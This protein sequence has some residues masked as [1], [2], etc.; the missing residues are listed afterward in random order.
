[1]FH[2]KV[3]ILVLNVDL[4]MMRNFFSC[5]CTDGFYMNSSLIS[6]LTVKTQIKQQSHSDTKCSFDITSPSILH[7]VRWRYVIQIHE[8]L[9]LE[10]VWDGSVW[11][12]CKWRENTKNKLYYN[13]HF[14]GQGSQTESISSGSVPL[15]HQRTMAFVTANWNPLGEAFYR[16]ACH[17]VFPFDASHLTN[18]NVDGYV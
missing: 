14:G 4:W 6:F 10:E 7:N 18:R 17:F 15:G 12:E 2:L 3:I 13:H 11:F 5:C 1:M 9:R 8:S 16:F